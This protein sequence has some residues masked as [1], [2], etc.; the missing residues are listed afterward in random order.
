MALHTVGHKNQ[1]SIGR[2][3]SAHLD[4][5]RLMLYKPNRVSSQHH[6]T[7]K[8]CGFGRKNKGIAAVAANGIGP[9]MQPIQAGQIQKT[10]L[11]FERINTQLLPGFDFP[12]IFLA[13]GHFGGAAASH[14]HEKK[15][16][17]AM[18]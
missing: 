6:C 12:D 16:R 2:N 9:L 5:A 3:I 1:G 11:A 8:S 10:G 17:Q 13:V 4:Q 7:Q 14:N 15:K 18:N